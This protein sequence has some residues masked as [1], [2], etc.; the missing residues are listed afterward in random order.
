VTLI[1]ALDRYSRVINAY[2]DG[3]ELA[4]ANGHDLSSVHSVASFFVS[5]VDAEMDQL[6]EAIGTD[7]A[8]ALKGK[9]ALANARLAYA[10]NE[11]AFSGSGWEALAAQ[12]AHKQRPLW[13]STGVKDA[14]VADTVYVTE[15]VVA[16]SVNTMPEISAC[17]AFQVHT[18]ITS[19]KG[20]CSSRW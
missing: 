6:L 3:L 16:D 2:L 11:R 19:I 1:F 8:S 12:G 5:R 9:A 17:E 15:L 10:L 18:W 14:H 7:D 13:A 4:A 20:S